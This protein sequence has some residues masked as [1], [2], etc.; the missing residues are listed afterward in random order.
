MKTL[1]L[2]HQGIDITKMQVNY[3][4]M[5]RELYSNF[6]L[7]QDK[8]FQKQLRKKHNLDSWFFD[9]CLTDVKMKISQDE[10]QKKKKLKRIIELEYILKNSCFSGNKGKRTKFRIIQK[11]NY[12]TANVNKKITFGSKS[13]LRK[14]SYLPNYIKQLTDGGEIE[15]SKKELALFKSQYHNTRILP[16][17]SIGESPQKSN[18]KFDFDFLNNKIFFKPEHG[19]KIQ[20]DFLC[21]KKQY[22]ELTKLQEQIGKQAITVRLDNKHV[23]ISFDNEKLNGFSFNEREYFKELKSI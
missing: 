19:V 6:E 10:T 15:K 18:R 13:V 9:S 20:I 5:F 8:G 23:Y 16:I 17:I 3:S 22:Q 4:S 11:L 12:L 2:R 21:S 1:K 7:S 14:I